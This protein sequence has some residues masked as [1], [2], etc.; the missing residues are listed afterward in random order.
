LQFSGPKKFTFY[1]KNVELL[2][3]ILYSKQDK[4]RKFFKTPIRGEKTFHLWRKRQFLVKIHK[5]NNSRKKLITK[6]KFVSR[7]IFSMVRGC[8]LGRFKN[9]KI[10]HSQ[11]LELK[12]KRDKI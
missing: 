9:I 7:L 6:N 12:K 2:A 4:F 8:G 1:S 11:P 10:V 5:S 3:F